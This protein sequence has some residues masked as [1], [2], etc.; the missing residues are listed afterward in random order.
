MAV[1]KI[2]VASEKGE[3]KVYRGQKK[4]VRWENA[5]SLTLLIVT[6]ILAKR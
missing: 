4:R 3:Q 5:D 1:L 2:D 6:L